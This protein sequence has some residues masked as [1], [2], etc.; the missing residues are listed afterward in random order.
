[1]NKSILD[2]IKDE[3]DIIPDEYDLEKLL[4]KKENEYLEKLSYNYRY[5]RDLAAY[6]ELKEKAEAGNYK[7]QYEL[8]FKFEDILSNKEIDE[9][10]FFWTTKAYESGLRKAEYLLHILPIIKELIVKAENGD[11]DAQYELGELYYQRDDTNKSVAL[12]IKAADQGHKR[13]AYSLGQMY[14]WFEDWPGFDSEKSKYYYNIAFENGY[15]ETEEQ[16]IDRIYG[17]YDEIM[18]M[19]PY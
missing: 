9:N 4:F 10:R 2:N 12:Y 5:N 8:G 16:Y 13:A 17:D 15:I 18:E 3:S 19:K 11:A 6:N 7:A 1:M 14:R